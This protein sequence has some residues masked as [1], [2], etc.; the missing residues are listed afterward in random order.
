MCVCVCHE[1]LP[2][3]CSYASSSMTT[4]REGQRQG[5]GRRAQILRVSR[6]FSGPALWIYCVGDTLICR[7]PELQVESSRVEFAGGRVGAPW[8]FRAHCFM[9]RCCSNLKCRCCCVGCSAGVAS[10]KWNGEGSGRAAGSGQRAEANGNYTT[11]LVHF[12]QLP[13]GSCH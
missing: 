7:V 3:P 9:G 11:H 8:Q 1:N 12:C 13:Q 10:C 2:A 6:A 4:G 5:G